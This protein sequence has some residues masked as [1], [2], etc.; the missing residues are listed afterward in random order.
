M[1]EAPGRYRDVCQ[2]PA[3][4]GYDDLSLDGAPDSARRLLVGAVEHRDGAAGQRRG[5]ARGRPAAMWWPGARHAAAPANGRPGPRPAPSRPSSA[6]GRVT[7]H[8]APSR[9]AQLQRLAAVGLSRPPR[10]PPRPPPPRKA[11]DQHGSTRRA[12]CQSAPATSAAAN[13]LVAVR[14]PAPSGPIASLASSVPITPI[15]TL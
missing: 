1:N 7:N 12:A 3:R 4:P 5:P 14:A 9:S 11:A 13:S 10:R 8:C 15:L 6:V 2:S